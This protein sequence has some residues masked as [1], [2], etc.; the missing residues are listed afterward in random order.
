MKQ[1]KIVSRSGR[2]TLPE[3]PS[4]REHRHDSDPPTVE[5]GGTSAARQTGRRARTGGPHFKAS[6]RNA[7]RRAP[8]AQAR[9]GEEAP[10]PGRGILQP[11]AKNAPGTD[12]SAAASVEIRHGRV[13][14]S[15]RVRQILRGVLK[16]RAAKRL[17]LSSPLPCSPSAKGRLRGSRGLRQL[18]L[19]RQI[20]A[21]AR[22]S[23]LRP[24]RRRV[25]A[26]NDVV[27]FRSVPTLRPTLKPTRDHSVASGASLLGFK[28]NWSHHDQY[29]HPFRIGSSHRTVLQL[30]LY[31]L[32]LMPL[33]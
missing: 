5:G 11:A 12:G 31:H 20:P 2:G 15:L 26:S 9:A 10:F 8:E 3:L 17:Q 4:G 22:S 27:A 25:F 1:R 23:I 6:C 28:F 14:W 30:L 19:R 18:R 24:I 16:K 33:S 7:V 32:P 29:H 13:V 21:A